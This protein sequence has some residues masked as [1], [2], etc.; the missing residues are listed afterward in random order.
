MRHQQAVELLPYQIRRFT[1]QH[2]TRSSQMSLE[3]V[4]RSLSG[5]GLA[6]R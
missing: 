5:K 3:F 2:D 1:A 4:E 6:R